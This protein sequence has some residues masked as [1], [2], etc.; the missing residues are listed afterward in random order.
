MDAL[1]QARAEIDEV[2]AQLAAL[3]ERRMAAVLQ[4]GRKKPGQAI[5]HHTP[6]CG[7]R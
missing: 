2:D 6:Y 4:V 5:S 3:F 1:E 7:T